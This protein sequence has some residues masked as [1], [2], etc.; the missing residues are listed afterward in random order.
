MAT[1]GIKGQYDK[2]NKVITV[3][4]HIHWSLDHIAHH[5]VHKPTPSNVYDEH[6]QFWEKQ[7]KIHYGQ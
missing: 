5:K 1:R 6:G 3:V 4:E 2:H 7:A